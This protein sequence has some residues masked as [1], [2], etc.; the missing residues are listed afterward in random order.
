MTDLTAERRRYADALREKCG[1][2]SATLV[3]AL[4][5]VPRERYLG[6]GPWDLLAAPAG[7]PLA[8]R[9]TPDA[10]PVHLYQDVLVSIDSAR[11]IHNGQ[12]SF[13]ASL[14]DALAPAPGEHVV[15]VGCGTGYYTAVMAEMVGPQ[16]RVTAI[17][18]DPTLAARARENL[19]PLAHVSVVLGD[20]TRHDP[21]PADAI[22]VNAGV[23]HPVPMWLDR[24]RP[25][26][27]LAL[28]LTV[29]AP[30]GTLGGVFTIRRETQGYGAE[31]LTPV[32]IFGCVGG[33]EPD[34][35]RNLAAAIERGGWEAVR[36]LRRDA[37]APGTDCWLHGDGFCFSQR[38]VARS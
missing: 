38:E 11:H 12:P 31:L 29:T 3:R 15:H 21:G 27:R 8:Y 9:A 6:P 33:R 19:A 36:S 25:G 34:E 23:T 1:L 32:G 16:G 22:L 10:D 5:T 37:H 30:V 17:D 14:I 18:V 13:L 2:R 35:E 4:A 24:L 7:L 28:P 20:G 26:G